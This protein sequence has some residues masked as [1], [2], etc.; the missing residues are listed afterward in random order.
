MSRFSIDEIVE[1]SGWDHQNGTL[2]FNDVY[3]KDKRLL[4]K[5]IEEFEADKFIC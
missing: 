3:Y 5:E 4:K 2:K 1:I